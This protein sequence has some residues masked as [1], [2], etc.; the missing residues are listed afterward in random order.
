MRRPDGTHHARVA[1]WQYVGGAIFGVIL[2]VPQASAATATSSFNVTMT[3]QGQC[4]VAS[5][6]NLQFGTVGVLANPVTASSTIGVQCTNTTPYNVG[7]NAGLG[8]GATVTTRK[9]TGGGTTV[10]YTLYRDAGY[11]QIWGITVGTDTVSGTGTG[12]VQNLTVY[13]QVPAQ[14]TPAPGSYTDTVQVTVT[15]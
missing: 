12:A 14:T 2:S 8:T 4:T 11:T 3:I 6:T 7:L 5:A 1:P 13:G 15:Y 10:N 9:M